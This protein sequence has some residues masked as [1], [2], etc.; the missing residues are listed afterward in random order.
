MTHQKCVVVFLCGIHIG[1][2]KLNHH[3][4]NKN[5]QF[6]SPILQAN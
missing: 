1:N 2:I 6:S 3:T 4:D 5:N